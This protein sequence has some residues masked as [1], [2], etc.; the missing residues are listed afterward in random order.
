MLEDYRAS[1]ASKSRQPVALVVSAFSLRGKPRKPT[2]FSSRQLPAQNLHSRSRGV[3]EKPKQVMGI[4]CARVYETAT[5]MKQVLDDLLGR[6]NMDF[7]TLLGIEFE[8]LWSQITMFAH[9]SATVGVSIEYLRADEQLKVATAGSWL[10]EFTAQRLC[11]KSSLQAGILNIRFVI[12]ETLMPDTDDQGRNN[13]LASRRPGNSAKLSTALISKRKRADSASPLLSKRPNSRTSGTHGFREPGLPASV[14]RGMAGSSNLLSSAQATSRQPRVLKSAFRIPAVPSSQWSREVSLAD[15]KFTRSTAEYQPSGDVNISRVEGL[16][17][18]SIA[19]DWVKGEELSMT[20]KHYETGFIGC[21]FTKRAI[22]ARYNDKEYVITQPSD[23]TMS[24][25]AVREVLIAELTLLAQCDGIK[26]KFDEFIQ[27]GSVE[28]VP[29]F[30]FNFKDSFYGEIEPLSAS[31]RR[32]MPHIGFLATPLLPCGRYDDPIRK[33][34]GSDNLGPA[35]DSLTQAI[36]AFVH[37][38]WIYSREQ[39]LFCDMQGTRDHKKKMCLI[40]PQAHTMNL[41]NEGTIYW[42]GGAMK[43]AAWKE[44]HLTVGSDIR[45][46]GLCEDNWVCSALELSNLQMEDLD[47]EGEPKSPASRAEK[48]KLGYVLNE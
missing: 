10:K 3:E 21:G 8:I 22:Y 20:R 28:G 17:I 44:Q 45:E 35:K 34:T 14:T 42:D 1:K 40:D 31:G 30:Y 9:E 25:S 5:P 18:I 13:S 36:H 32:T 33:F 38:A 15:Y 29:A 43:I 41:R 23:D 27:D 6:L 46:D 4:H 12:E 19:E 24:F 47:D 39:V 48:S 11:A 2:G 16:E 37:F 7:Q 26:Q